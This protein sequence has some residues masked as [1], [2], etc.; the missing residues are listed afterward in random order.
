M[1]QN[2]L[3]EVPQTRPT[4]LTVLCILSYVGVAIAVIS[5]IYNYITFNAN[6][7]MIENLTGGIENL[8]EN[9]LFA[10]MSDLLK[11]GRTLYIVN[12]FAALICLV[13]V[14]QM[15][16][17]KKTG[18][19]IYIVG[20]IAPAIASFT[21]VGSVGIL[22]TAAIIGGLIFPILFIV[23]YGLNLKHMS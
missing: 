20:E 7:A 10:G 1:E 8:E 15:W 12:I 23:L 4:F 16:K 3:N 6:M 19:Y 21:L 5:G 2:T 22:G 18:Y 14:L 13:G 17:M 11:H 9:P